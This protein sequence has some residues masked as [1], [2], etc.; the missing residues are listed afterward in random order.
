MPEEKKK[1][2]RLP[3]AD[4]IVLANKKRKRLRLLGLVHEVE[5]EIKDL[6]KAIKKDE[7]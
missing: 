4:K 6:E 3:W 7:K 1:H 5:K 2:E